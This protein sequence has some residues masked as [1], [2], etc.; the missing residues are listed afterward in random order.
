MRIFFSILLS[1]SAPLLTNVLHGV[2]VTN[3]TL[4]TNNVIFDI[5][6]TID[7]RFPNNNPKTPAFTRNIIEIIDRTNGNNAWVVNSTNAAGRSI[8][9]NT[10]SNPDQVFFTNTAGG[11]FEGGSSGSK[12]QM[13][14]SG[15]FENGD[16]INATI[17]FSRT[18]SPFN[19]FN[20]S[21]I[22]VS[23]LIVI[24]GSDGVGTDNDLTQIGSV[25]TGAVPEPSQYGFLLG[26]SGFLLVFL[27][28][29]NWF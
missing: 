15:D 14:G 24:W 6:G 2:N 19:V 21:A 17:G 23:D 25:Y 4:T 26:L 27:R 18:T 16:Y 8:T 22:D 28:R 1:L 7:L 10:T 3:F 12:I 11:A 20:T 13:L 9:N 29:K 5:E